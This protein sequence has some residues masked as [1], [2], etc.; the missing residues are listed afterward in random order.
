MHLKEA[1]EVKLFFAYT[2]F[3]NEYFEFSIAF[4]KTA[5]WCLF[6][7]RFQRVCENYCDNCSYRYDFHEKFF[8]YII[9]ISPGFTKPQYKNKYDTYPKKVAKLFEFL[10]EANSRL[11]D[12]LVLKCLT[13]VKEDKHVIA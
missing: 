6:D 5:D 12:E 2:L 13:Q 11:S 3:S 7:H 8:I 4:P 10:E 1:F 9:L